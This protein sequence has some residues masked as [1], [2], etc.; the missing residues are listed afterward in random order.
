MTAETQT[1]KSPSSTGLPSAYAT[2]SVTEAS[3]FLREQLLT[4][5]HRHTPEI[6]TVVRDSKA[7]AGLEPRQMARALH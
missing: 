6:E 4:V 3:A 1:L 2:R 5:I 7:G